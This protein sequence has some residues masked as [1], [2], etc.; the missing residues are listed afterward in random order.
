VLEQDERLSKLYISKHAKLFLHPHNQSSELKGPT[1]VNDMAPS[2]LTTNANGSTQ[3]ELH[4]LLWVNA[5]GLGG[6]KEGQVPSLNFQK[7]SGGSIG[8]DCD[9][10]AGL[11]RGSRNRRPSHWVEEYELNGDIGSDNEDS[12]DEKDC[13][14]DDRY[15]SPAERKGPARVIARDLLPDDA[16]RRLRHVDASARRVNRADLDDEDVIRIR[17]AD[18][19]ARGLARRG[20]D[21]AARLK[22]HRKN[23][24]AHATMTG[25]WDLDNTCRFE[26]NT[27]LYMWIFIVQIF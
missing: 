3:L 23:N 2:I 17:N 8:A 1:N 16:R 20:V 9:G 24:P 27:R 15:L 18:T 5:F 4:C 25:I 22:E 11:R 7:Q 13:S 19:F 14:K 21:T 26:S 6:S 12:N 10:V